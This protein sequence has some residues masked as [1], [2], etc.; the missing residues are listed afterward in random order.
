MTM[1][2]INKY[3]KILAELNEQIDE[4]S[5]KE[6]PAVVVY[7]SENGNCSYRKEVFG[8]ESKYIKSTATGEITLT[9]QGKEFYYLMGWISKDDRYSFIQINDNTLHSIVCGILYSE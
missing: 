7:K 1:K 2:K 3:I 5:N 8:I 4:L 6:I 9:P